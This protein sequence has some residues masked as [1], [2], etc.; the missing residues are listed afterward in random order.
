MFEIWVK[1]PDDMWSGNLFIKY[2]SKVEVVHPTWFKPYLAGPNQ[3]SFR[4]KKVWSHWT[5]KMVNLSF[6]QQIKMLCVV[7]CANISWEAQSRYRRCTVWMDI[8]TDR[9]LLHARQLPM[10]K[11][12]AIV[13]N[14]WSAVSFNGAFVSKDPQLR[15]FVSSSKCT[16]LGTCQRWNSF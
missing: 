15:G 16:F 2:L 9:K 14:G 8:L 1:I 7:W 10:S 11:R 13:S 12:K 5:C 4:S 6:I 3:N